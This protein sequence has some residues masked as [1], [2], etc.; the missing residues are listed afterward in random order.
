MNPKVVVI[1]LDGAKLDLLIPWTQAGHLP[2]ISRLIQQGISGPLTSTFP[3]LTGP[4]WSSFMTGKSPGRHGILEFFR[5]KGGSYKQVLN[6]R[7]DID[8]KSI[9][10]LLS[11]REK[12]VGVIGIPLTY[13]PE[14]VNGSQL[15]V[16]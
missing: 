15:L 7:F 3:P 1:G 11:E 8:D 16:T 9:W 14:P 5:R 4:A 2:N 12:S 13:S 10:G 6:S